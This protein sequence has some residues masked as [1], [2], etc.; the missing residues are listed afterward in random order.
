[1]D[2]LVPILML[3]LSLMLVL[4][5]TV[6]GVKAQEADSPLVDITSPNPCENIPGP[7]EIIVQ[8]TASD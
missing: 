3:L 2:V 1:M 6:I 4:V 7:K 8:G 5:S